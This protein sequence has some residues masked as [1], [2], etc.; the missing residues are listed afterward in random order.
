MAAPVAF[1]DSS[2]DFAAAEAC[3]A[4]EEELCTDCEAAGKHAALLD[5]L[6]GTRAP[7]APTLKGA[8]KSALLLPAGHATDITDAIEEDGV[9]YAHEAAHAALRAVL[10]EDKAPIKGGG[11]LAREASFTT[12]RLSES[13]SALPKDDFLSRLAVAE[14]VPPSPGGMKARGLI[15][16][17]PSL[18]SRGVAAL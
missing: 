18:F 10:G 8:P 12:V 15:P 4:R 13:M 1:A 7:V 14:E 3:V 2:A 17:S 11:A 9:E 16:P 5:G 6:R